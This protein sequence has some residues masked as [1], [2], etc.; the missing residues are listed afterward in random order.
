MTGG[1][2]EGSETVWVRYFKYDG[3]PH[4]SYP[5][6]LVARR[7]EGS[8]L[9]VAAGTVATLAGGDAVREEAYTLL[10]PS[11]A[12]WT[13]MFNAAP[14]RTEVYCDITTPAIWGEGEV[15]LVDLDLDVRRRRTGEI[16]LLDE[17]EFAEHRARY[18]YPD[19]V[20][21]QAR[22]AAHWLVGA[23]GDGTEPFASAYRPWLDAAI[24]A[25]PAR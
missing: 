6:R 20:V 4:R 25:E 23:L 22:A 1:E 18:G 14:R 12:W 2:P 19:Q 15:S 11:D 8:W 10:V 16:E 3:T 17:D 24:A 5:A 7:P 21:A 13:A 9:L